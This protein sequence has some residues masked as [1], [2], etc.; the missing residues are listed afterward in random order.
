MIDS[1]RTAPDA[2]CV[3]S[4]DT[5]SIDIFS[6]E[7]A[8]RLFHRLAVGKLTFTRNGPWSLA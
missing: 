6:N 8:R 1:D 5:I 7:A 3:I 2:R 4:F